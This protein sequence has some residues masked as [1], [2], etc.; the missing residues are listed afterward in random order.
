MPRETEPSFN[1]R[2]FLL[3]ALQDNLRLDGRPLDA[4]RHLDIS[5]GDDYGVA[6]VRLGK[7]RVLTRISASIAA[8]RPDRKFDGIFTITT[9]LSP[10]ASPAFESGRQ[11]DLETHLSRILETSLRRSQALS[12]ESLCLVAGQKVWSLRADVHVLDYDGGLVDACCL[13]TLAAL[14]HFRIADTSITGG[15]LTVYTPLERDPVPLA[16]LHHPLCVTLN[17]FES[18][19]KWLVDATLMEQQC[20]QGEI[21][22]AA[23]PQG[24]VCLVQKGGGGQVDALLVLRCVEVAMVKVRELDKVMDGALEGDAKRRDKGGMSRE[25]RAE[26][27]R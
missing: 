24:E 16:L 14:R 12:T 2:A 19:E 17:F 8:P 27:E 21:V 11:S 7:T 1:E 18:G 13:S 15:E 5:F 4:Y 25:L 10:L 3:Q 6:D 20:S 23:N 9:E 22:V 26:N